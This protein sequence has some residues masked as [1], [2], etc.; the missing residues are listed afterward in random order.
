MGWVFTPRTPVRGTEEPVGD[1]PSRS[2]ETAPRPDRRAGR[3]SRTGPRRQATTAGST[4]TAARP[5]EAAIGRRADA[6]DSQPG[7]TRSRQ[8]RPRPPRHPNGSRQG[9]RGTAD[10]GHQGH[11][12][13]E[14]QGQEGRPK[15]AKA[16]EGDQGGRSRPRPPR[17][18]SRPRRPPRRRRPRSREAQPRRPR[19]RKK[20]EEGD[21]H[22]GDQEGAAKARRKAAG[23]KSSEEDRRRQGAG[24]R[25]P[26]A[27]KGS[28]PRRQ[29]RPGGA[30]PRRRH[31][32][33]V[34]A[35]NDPMTFL[36]FVAD[37]PVGST[38]DGTV[39]SFTSHGA[40]IDVGGMLCHVP[41]R[42]LRRSAAQQ[43][44]LRSSPRGRP[45]TF[46]AGVA[47]RRRAAGP[48]SRC[49]AS[50]RLSRSPRPVARLGAPSDNLGTRAEPTTTCPIATPSSS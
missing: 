21:G 30:R 48:S 12:G 20:P 22:Q 8:E 42:G 15:A 28:A 47:R 29:P 23:S 33:R 38:F 14:G 24:P 7:Q 4:T 37:H 19:R 17:R 1:R 34:E 50:R 10:Q 44:P 13:G 45:V 18:R 6:S 35:L 32:S 46:V 3:P 49:P 36:T 31:R 9:C 2:A 27:G 41:L 25:A 43:G 5:A 11:Q 39:V 16:G 40:H 26:R